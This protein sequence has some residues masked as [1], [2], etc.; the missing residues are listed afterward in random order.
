MDGHQNANPAEVYEQYLGPAIADPWTRVLLDYAHPQPGEDVLD[1]ACGTGSVA[2]H[3]APLVGV[4]GKIVALDINPEMLAV[5]RAIHAPEGASIEWLDGDAMDLPL[6]DRAFEIVLCQQGLQFFSDRAAALREMRRVL[7][8]GGRVVLSVWQSLELHPVYQTLFE[9]TIRHLGVPLSDVAVPFSLSG[10]EELRTLLNDAGF[11]RTDIVP[12]QL[13]IR[14]PSPARFVQLTIL[15]AATSVPAFSQLD[16]ATRLALVE[17]VASE[18]DT[19]I[20]RYS[21]GD[22]LMLPMFTHIA[23]GYI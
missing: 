2:R 15:G 1:V 7:V 11:Q 6:P 23:V 4:N 3:I 22:E 17:A 19:V 10:A 18:T 13:D 9:A 12:R 16:A 5:G 20:K 21:N 14:L 8:D